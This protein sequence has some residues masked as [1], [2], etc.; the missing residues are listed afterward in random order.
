M[1]LPIPNPFHPSLPFC[2]LP[3]SSAAVRRCHHHYDQNEGETQ[4][5]RHPCVA[6]SGNEGVRHKHVTV[7]AATVLTPHSIGQTARAATA[8]QL[9]VDGRKLVHHLLVVDTIDVVLE[10]CG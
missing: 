3:L 7:A 6:T 10:L 5:P 4:H 2:P 1:L 8:K 9:T